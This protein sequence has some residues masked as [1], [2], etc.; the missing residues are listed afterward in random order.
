MEKTAFELVEDFDEFL[1][2]N[3]DTFYSILLRRTIIASNI[4]HR[5]DKENCR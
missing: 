1:V 4:H 5:M 2:I 3:V